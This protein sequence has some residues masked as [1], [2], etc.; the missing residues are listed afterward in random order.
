MTKREQLYRAA[1]KRQQGSGWIVTHWDDARGLWIES[2]EMS[3][4]Q[5]VAFVQEYREAIE[6]EVKK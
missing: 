6:G 4:G 5:A 1:H 2:G 3:Y